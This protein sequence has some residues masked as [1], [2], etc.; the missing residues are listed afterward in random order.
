MTSVE[1]K[2]AI[3]VNVKD[4]GGP[5]TWF[6]SGIGTLLDVVAGNAQRIDAVSLL[7]SGIARSEPFTL[8]PVT[9][10]REIPGDTSVPRYVYRTLD[11]EWREVGTRLNSPVPQESVDCGAALF[12]LCNEPK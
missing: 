9:E 5:D 4:E 11:G 3:K 8:V 6:V 7:C 12:V 2:F 1:A 10:I